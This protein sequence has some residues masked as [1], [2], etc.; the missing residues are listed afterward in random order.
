M[1]RSKRNAADSVRRRHNPRHPQLRTSS[2]PF[3]SNTRRLDRCVLFLTSRG[4]L[5]TSPGDVRVGDRICAIEGSNSEFIVRRK[6]RGYK[7]VGR[8]TVYRY[9]SQKVKQEKWN[10]TDWIEDEPGVFEMLLV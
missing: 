1:G 10:P 5:A 7:L 8:A 9:E 2:P 6:D 3:D 4:N